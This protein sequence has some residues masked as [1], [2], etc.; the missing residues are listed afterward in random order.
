MSVQGLAVWGLVGEVAG[1]SIVRIQTVPVHGRYRDGLMVCS[2]R[3]HNPPRH[4]RRRDTQQ[5]QQHGAAHERDV[6]LLPVAECAQEGHGGK[7]GH[8][9]GKRQL[10]VSAIEQGNFVRDGNQLVIGR[11][12]RTGGRFD[13]DVVWVIPR[14]ILQRLLSPERVQHVSDW[15]R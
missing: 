3:M 1:I 10:M 13:L 15:C 6:A 12:S 8:A 4:T 11:E 2:M 5:H 7:N 9:K 14:L